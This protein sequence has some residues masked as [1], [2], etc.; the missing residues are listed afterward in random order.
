MQY[1][2]QFEIG[3]LQIVIRK[4][5]VKINIFFNDIM[6]RASWKG[7]Q[8]T[9]SLLHKFLQITREREKL[10]KNPYSRQK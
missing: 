4:L 7:L 2:L 6:E 8:L 9:I 1:I 3:S 10:I 5:W